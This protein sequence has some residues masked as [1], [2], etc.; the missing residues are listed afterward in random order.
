MFRSHF[1]KAGKFYEN[2]KNFNKKLSFK[3][4]ILFFSSQRLYKI[5]HWFEEADKHSKLLATYPLKNTGTIFAMTLLPGEFIY[6]SSEDN[7]SQY[8]LAQCSL[9]TMC[10]QCAVD[11]YCSWNTARGL[12]YKREQAHLSAIG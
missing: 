2:N 3:K 9:H 8:F 5:A 7:V 11:P 1:V 6:L 12:C 4:H 10:A